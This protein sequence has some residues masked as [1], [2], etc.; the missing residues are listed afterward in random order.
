[1][2]DFFEVQKELIRE[3]EKS[4]LIRTSCALVALSQ[5]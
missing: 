2:D 5:A 4:W 3:E 1:M